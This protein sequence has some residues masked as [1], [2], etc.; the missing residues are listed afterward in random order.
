MNNID[1]MYKV[2]EIMTA[3]EITCSIQRSVSIKPSIKR[4]GNYIGLQAD[5][6]YWFKLVKWNVSMKNWHV[7]TEVIKVLGITDLRVENTRKANIERD[8][9]AGFSIKRGTTEL[10]HLI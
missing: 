4:Y 5:K 6:R 2:I 10:F 3:N 9:S 8:T 1:I 7:A